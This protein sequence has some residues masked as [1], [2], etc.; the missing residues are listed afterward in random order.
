ME[1]L[2]KIDALINDGHLSYNDLNRNE[3][4]GVLE[5]FLEE[6]KV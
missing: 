3:K 2:I 6:K 4:V 1:L 5:T